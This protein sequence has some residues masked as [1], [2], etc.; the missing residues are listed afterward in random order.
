MAFGFAADPTRKWRYG[1]REFLPRSPGSPGIPTRFPGHDVVV[2]QLRLAHEFQRKLVEIELA[3]RAAHEEFLR[4]FSV[5]YAAAESLVASLN[6]PEMSAT[7][8]SAKAAAEVGLPADA[9]AGVVA[10][11]VAEE[12]G[13]ERRAAGIRTPAEDVSD[14]RVYAHVEHKGRRYYVIAESRHPETRLPLRVRLTTLDGMAPFWVD[15]QDC[16]LIRTYEPREV[17]V[18]FRGRT[19]TVYT[20]VGSLRQFRDDQEAGRRAGHP[21][22]AACGKRSDRLV[23]DHEDGLR[24]CRACCDMPGDE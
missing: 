19:E 6:A 17:R 22:C 1:L 13:D 20:T 12:T 23:T 14:C 10:D 8:Q 11:K 3:R 7:R 15:A 18:G 24:K 16:T 9:P 2:I 4:G 21:Q 5:A